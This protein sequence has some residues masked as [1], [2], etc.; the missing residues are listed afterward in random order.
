M[1]NK[2]TKGILS[3]GTGQILSFGHTNLEIP[4]RPPG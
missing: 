4:V 2:N 1:K 3:L